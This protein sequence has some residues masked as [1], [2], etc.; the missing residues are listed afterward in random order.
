MARNKIDWERARRLYRLGQ[1]TDREIAGLVGCAPV[2]VTRR[3]N[4]EG[5]NR[6]L[7]EQVAQETRAQLSAG[8]AGDEQAVADAAEVAAGIVRKHRDHIMTGRELVMQLFAE[9]GEVGKAPVMVEEALRSGLDPDEVDLG[10]IL[11]A[12]SSGTRAKSVSQ[13]AGALSK[14]VAAER[15]AYNL[16]EHRTEKPY[17]KMLREL[18]EGDE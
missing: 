17:E 18:F 12:Y 10:L 15:V 6:D 9:I 14:L 1:L 13:L 16:D 8:E 3:A 4:K 2:T 11:A 7:T 5:W